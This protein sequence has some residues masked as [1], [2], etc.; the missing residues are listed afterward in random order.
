MTI[1]SVTQAALA[2]TLG[3]LSI[4]STFAAPQVFFDFDLVTDTL[5][6]GGK[7]VAARSAFLATT[8]NSSS[9]GFETFATGT[10][11]AIGSPLSVLGG[12]ASLAPVG[13]ITTGSIVRQL[14][15]GNSG[16]FNTTAGCVVGTTCKWW[17]TTR[18]F[19]LTFTDA[20]SAL[21]FY[22]TDFN[23]FKS[24]L[25]IDFV[26]DTPAVPGAFGVNASSVLGSATLPSVG[27]S[28]GV[29]FFGYVSDSFKFNRVVFKIDQSKASDPQDPSTFDK[30]GFDD[31][32]AGNFKGPVVLPE[33]ASLGLVGLSIGLLALSRRRKTA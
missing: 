14:P 23:D 21:G 1:R 24:S 7:S 20:V 22:G 31:V 10:S 8:S 11:P 2:A 17:E 27:S 9:E 6:A 16:R 33:P 5:P 28:G 18:S 32:I 25:T 26:L 3:C 29:L 4:T 13:E 15:N 12:A 30:L 19:E